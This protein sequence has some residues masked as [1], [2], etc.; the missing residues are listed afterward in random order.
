MDA[1]DR[2]QNRHLGTSSAISFHT[3]QRS[4]LKTASKETRN[5]SFLFAVQKVADDH[6]VIRRLVDSQPFRSNSASTFRD[7]M[8]WRELDLGSIG[9]SGEI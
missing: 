5:T 9:R 6:G 7:C 3:V 4:I 2:L 1:A 8:R